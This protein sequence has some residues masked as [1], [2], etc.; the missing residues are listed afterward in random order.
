MS[1]DGAVVRALASYYCDLGLGSRLRVICGLSLLLVLALALRIFPPGLPF[2]S[3]PLPT[4]PNSNL[5]WNLRATGLIYF[6]SKVK[7]APVLNVEN[8]YFYLDVQ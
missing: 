3:F 5:I 2:F 4:F 1:R 6:L 8:Y 7:Y